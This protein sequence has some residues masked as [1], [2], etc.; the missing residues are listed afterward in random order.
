MI[1]FFITP[2][3]IALITEYIDGLPLDEYI[4]Y[5][6][7]AGDEARARP[8]FMKLVDAVLYCHECGIAHR[9]LK[10]ENVLV[11]RDGTDLRL[12]G[13]PAAVARRH[14]RRGA[15]S[16]RCARDTCCADF[17]ISNVVESCKTHCGTYEFAAPEMVSKQP[18]NATL[19][20]AWSLGV[21]LYSMLT[22]RCDARDGP[23]C[24]AVHRSRMLADK[25]PHLADYRSAA[26]MMITLRRYGSASIVAT[27]Q[28]SFRPT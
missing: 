10:T 21:I 12:I 14:A 27:L 24:V 15:V 6:N 28:S 16:R 17:G 2:E 5:T 4:D 26:T 20:D 13:A 9:D 22:N 8:L 7:L 3:H 1:E 11:T 19:C 25:G 23:P 18:Y